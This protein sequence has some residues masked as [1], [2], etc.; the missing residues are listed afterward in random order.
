[1][2]LGPPDPQNLIRDCICSHL[3][4]PRSVSHSNVVIQIEIAHCKL[5]KLAKDATAIRPQHLLDI[6]KSAEDWGDSSHSA[7]ILEII[8]QEQ[9]IKKWKRI[10]YT[11]RQT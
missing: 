2:G 3:F 6:Q 9:E 5:A 11:T 7:I 4:D 8:T 10:N 1:M